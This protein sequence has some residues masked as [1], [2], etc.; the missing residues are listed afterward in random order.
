[1]LCIRLLSPN[2]CETYISVCPIVCSVKTRILGFQE[3]LFSA[4]VY[5]RVAYYSLIFPV[6]SVLLAVLALWLPMCLP[7]LDPRLLWL[8][9]RLPWLDLRLPWLA[10]LC[11]LQMVRLVYGKVR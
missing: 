6:L 5:N 9:L 2:P 7:W 3:D 11:A 4:F 1:M 10:V 8:D